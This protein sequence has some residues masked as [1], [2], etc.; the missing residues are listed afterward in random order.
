MIN[1]KANLK[2]VLVL[3]FA[4]F[5]MFFGA[6]NLIFP[7]YLG[8]NTADQWFVGFICFILADVGLAVLAMLMLART[9]KGAVGITE[10]LG[11]KVS[12][13]LIAANA[14]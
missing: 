11:S 12:F 5:A 9:G 6:G 7:P 8:F 4:L 3:G 10:V 2:D 13:L 14:I 1:K